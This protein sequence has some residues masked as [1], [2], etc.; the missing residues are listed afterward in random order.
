MLLVTSDAGWRE[1]TD[2]ADVTSA[3]YEA[4]DASDQ[5][6][7]LEPGLRFPKE[8][9]LFPKTILVQFGIYIYICVCTHI[10]CSMVFDGFS[11]TSLNFYT[12][13]K[14]GIMIIL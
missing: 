3:S 2:A 5:P 10:G 14:K 7:R 6:N 4:T 13:P 1:T 8:E 12:V 9:E 11:S